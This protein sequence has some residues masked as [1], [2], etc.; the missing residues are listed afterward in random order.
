MPV[1]R[2]LRSLQVYDILA[3]LIPGTTF[4]VVLAATV[5][6]ERSLETVGS[7]PLLASFVV[8]GFVIGHVIQSL[9]STL[10]GPPRL[11]GLLVDETRSRDLYDP[12]G[13]AEFLPTRIRDWLGFERADLDALT[14]TS[15]EES[16]WPMAKD[17]FDLSDDFWH[18]GR[19]MQ[20][21]LSY[22]ETVPATRALRFQSIHTFHR[23][24]W[25][26]WMLAL[27]AVFLV[28]LGDA[29]GLLV[30]RPPSVLAVVA[31]FSL[32]GIHIFGQR[33]EKFNRKVVEYA[34]VDFY[35]QRSGH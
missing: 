21:T 13:T 7:G 30:G 4:L 22:L 27:F 1:A 2:T 15:V 5:P 16:F 14:I 32:A 34:V 23:S 35:T 24:M 28:A 8:C 17:R 29:I 11:F 3:N 33:K 26:M 9:A 31:V 19:L 18:N 6:V 12:S 10:N 25:G 20:L